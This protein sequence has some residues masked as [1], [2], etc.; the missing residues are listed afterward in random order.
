MLG[1][2]CHAAAPPAAAPATRHTRST[3]SSAAAAAVPPS[4]SP[5]PVLTKLTSPAPSPPQ[6]RSR[7]GPEGG[8]AAAPRGARAT[9]PAHAPSVLARST[10]ELAETGRSRGELAETG[11]S[12][13]IWGEEK[14]PHMGPTTESAAPRAAGRCGAG[15]PSL[16]AISSPV[17]ARRCRMAP[18]ACSRTAFASAS[19]WSSEVSE[20]TRCRKAWSICTGSGRIL[21]LLV[22][23]RCA[24][25]RCASCMM[26]ALSSSRRTPLL[27]RAGGG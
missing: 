2:S 9:V 8:R 16:R 12:R 13:V 18:S 10:G 25:A 15:T 17:A 1:R 7:H 20:S 11:R 5:V 14:P 27:V 6:L 3:L 21:L 24:A 26:T 23:C 4:A 19:E 22:C